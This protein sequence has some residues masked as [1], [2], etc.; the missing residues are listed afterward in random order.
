MRAGRGGGGAEI[1]YVVHGR[2]G[3]CVVRVRLMFF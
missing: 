3:Q 1:Q 2:G